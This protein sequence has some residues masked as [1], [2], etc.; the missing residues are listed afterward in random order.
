MGL[1]LVSNSNRLKYHCPEGV[2]LW[3]EKA[4]IYETV[5]KCASAGSVQKV[6]CIALAMFARL[7]TSN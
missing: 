6:L 1:D 3:M 4:S 7:K 2:P 5:G